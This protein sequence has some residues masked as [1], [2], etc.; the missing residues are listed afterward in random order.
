MIDPASRQPKDS[1]ASRGRG[2]WLIMAIGFCVLAVAGVAGLLLAQQRWHER[3]LLLSLDINAI[4]RDSSLTAYATDEA[5]PLY[6]AHCARCHG[7]DLK[8]NAASGAPSLV[9]RYWLF[10]DGG[11]FDIERTLLYGIRSGHSKSHNVTDMPAFGLTGRL[12]AA[13]TRNLVQY[14][15]QLKGRPHQPLAASEGRALYH[16]VGKANC[17]DCHGEDGRGDSNYGAPD[18]TVNAANGGGEE[19]G[20]Y[21]AIY[22]GQHRIMPAWINVLSLEQIRALAIYVY[23]VGK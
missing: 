17:G 20:L 21:D 23:L 11:V 6:A 9:D 4:M 16:D 12:S 14:L 19:R 10:G 15:L 7:A 8:G 2:R 18:L 5:K 1:F 13:E 22:S 3:V